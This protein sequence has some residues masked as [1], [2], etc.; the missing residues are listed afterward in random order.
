MLAGTANGRGRGGVD[1]HYL[2][3]AS[4]CRCLSQMSQARSRRLGDGRTSFVRK[5]KKGGQR[6]GLSFVLFSLLN[7]AVLG[8]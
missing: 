1:I 8:W 6:T 3:E 7:Q 5:Q 2:I 4:W